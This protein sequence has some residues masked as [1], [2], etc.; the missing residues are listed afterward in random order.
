MNIELLRRIQKHILEEPL[1]LNMH[2]WAVNGSALQFGYH[3]LRAPPCGI[4]CCIG[5]W[6][7]ELSGGL[8]PETALELTTDEAI[9]LFYLRHWPKDLLSLLHQTSVQ[10]AEYAVIT[11]RR[12]DRFIR[13]NGRE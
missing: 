11:A 1:R 9:K 6:A 4:V 8:T 3:G 10:T 12:I 7:R 13:T 2:D 5:G